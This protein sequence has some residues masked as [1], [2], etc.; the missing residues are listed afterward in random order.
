LGRWT[1]AVRA[2]ALRAF[3]RLSSGGYDDRHDHRD[4]REDADE[5][6]RQSPSADLVRERQER[7]SQDEC[8]RSPQRDESRSTQT[9]AGIAG[10]PGP[11]VERPVRELRGEGEADRDEWGGQVEPGVVDREL[12][13]IRAG[14]DGDRG[15]DEPRPAVDDRGHQHDGRDG[16]DAQVSTLEL[17]VPARERED[18]DRDEAGDTADARR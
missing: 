1:V 5:I 15:R 14:D 16:R 2:A 7:G 8:D 12:G 17:V 11:L 4:R 13:C 10:R 3:T 9:F 18:R 6:E